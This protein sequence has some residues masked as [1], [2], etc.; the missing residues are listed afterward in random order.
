LDSGPA[1]CQVPTGAEGDAPANVETTNSTKP[2]GSAVASCGPSAPSFQGETKVNT[3]IC[4]KSGTSPATSFRT[5]AKETVARPLDHLRRMSK[6]LPG[7]WREMERLR[8][9][10]AEVGGYPSYC[11]L[12]TQGAREAALVIGRELTGFD[13]TI[14]S[15][16]FA[17]R[18]TQGIYRFDPTILEELWATPLTGG[19]PIEILEGLPEWCCYLAF[20]A[21][22]R[23]GGAQTAGFFVLLQFNLETRQPELNL[24]LDRTYTDA[25]SLLMPMA[26]P[27][28]GTLE[29]SLTSVLARMQE[30]VEDG[31]WKTIG[32]QSQ[33]GARRQL[34]RT[35]A[36]GRRLVEEL[37]SLVSVAIYLASATREMRSGTL[38]QPIL[39]KAK[40]TRHGGTTIFPSSAP[41]E[42]DVGFRIGAT[43]RAGLIAADREHVGSG[44]PRPHARPRPHMRRA[45]W[46]SFWTGPL[47]GD[48]KAI[49]HCLHPVLVA[50]GEYNLIVP[51]LHRVAEPLATGGAR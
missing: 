41:R 45:H 24:V 31:Y 30:D 50:A 48:R 28:I 3:A 23:I 7:L 49:L 18:A 15:A 14:L 9:R 29:E 39:P 21:L 26:L 8:Q 43:I 40:P 35:R 47:K 38:T 37:G 42:W 4:T 25:E 17:W 5:V 34:E 11:F 13:T 27:L 36:H 2:L 44:E 20:P 1:T 12:P 10:K 32:F 19:I 46:H 16:L 6:A 22:R 33:E 51:V